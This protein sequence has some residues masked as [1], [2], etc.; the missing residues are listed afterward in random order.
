M[1]KNKTFISNPT[2]NEI[3][4]VMYGVEDKILNDYKLIKKSLLDSLKK[5]KF[6]ILKIS[7]HQFKPQGYTIC[8]LLAESHAALHTYPEYN[9]LVFYL[10]SCRKEGDGKITLSHL[11]DNLKPKRKKLVQRVVKVKIN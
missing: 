8:V 9:S 4:C 2:G 10:Y 6:N 1:K 5:D 7:E 3:S 11:L